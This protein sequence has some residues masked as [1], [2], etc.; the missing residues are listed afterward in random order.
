MRSFLF[1]VILGLCLG[2]APK[3]A[4]SQSMIRDAEIEAGLRNLF[5]PILEAA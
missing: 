5:M 3:G 2:L 4:L 1:A